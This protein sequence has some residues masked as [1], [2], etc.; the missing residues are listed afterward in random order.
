MAFSC[1]VSSYSAALQRSTASSEDDLPL[2]EM[3]PA[4][5]A[6]DHSLLT[7]ALLGSHA[8]QGP[9]ASVSVLGE[10]MKLQAAVSA[11]AVALCERGRSSP[12]KLAA[13][14]PQLLSYATSMAPKASNA[15]ADKTYLTGDIVSLWHCATRGRKES[16]ERAQ[17]L[18]RFC[19]PTGPRQGQGV[20]FV[21]WSSE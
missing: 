18:T 2:L 11:A 16:G 4:S 3:P 8:C 5:F 7:E 13:S 6:F 15:A 17:T 20:P 21:A 14:A 1:S 9:S 19:A 12:A 10:S